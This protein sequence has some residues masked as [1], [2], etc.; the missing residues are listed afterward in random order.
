MSLP[1]VQTV[2]SCP[3][4]K[5]ELSQARKQKQCIYLAIIQ[6]CTTPE[7]FQ[8]HCVLNTYENETVE[9]CAPIILS[10]GTLRYKMHVSYRIKMILFKFGIHVRRV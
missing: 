4:N 9:V 5:A 2:P 7:N 8:Y 3:T 1:T 6:K 10:Q